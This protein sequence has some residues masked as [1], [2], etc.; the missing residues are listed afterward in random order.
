[1]TVTAPTRAAVLGGGSLRTLQRSVFV[2]LA[3]LLATSCGSDQ[4]SGSAADQGSRDA[5][6][7]GDADAASPSDSGDAGTSD[8]TIGEFS[9]QLVAPVEASGDVAAT[10]GFTTLLGKVYDGPQADAI[11]WD[12]DQ[13]ADGCT[14]LLPRV[15]FCDPGCGTAVCV[16]DDTCRAQPASKS[17]GKVTVKGVQTESGAK[18]FSV[19]PVQKTY[20]SGS[21]KLPYP[22]FAEGD[23]ITLTAA[24]ADLPGFTVTGKGIAPLSLSGAESFPIETGKPLTLRW[25]KAGIDVSRIQ[26]RLD[27]S[28]HGGTKGKIECDVADDGELVIPAAMLDRL[29][30]LGVAGFPTVIV[31]RS[32]VSSA[33]TTVGRINLRVYGYVE[34]AILLSGVTSCNEDA[35]C[36]SGKKCQDDLTCK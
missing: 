19:D 26:V 28:H 31:T 17:V 35:D 7:E 22:A 33:S 13:E 23:A 10:A 27:I 2:C 12:K 15:P 5:A 1:M 14:L 4:P 18:E 25:E 16:D 6:A 29:V 21:V 11:A 8:A 24:G 20:Q 9:L 3:A 34:R 30:S 36:A 32:A